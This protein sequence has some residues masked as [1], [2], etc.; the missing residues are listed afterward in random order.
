MQN[1]LT[2][3]PVVQAWL[4][5]STPDD[6]GLLARL[7]GSASRAVHGYLQRPS[8]LLH[9]CAETYDGP[10]GGRLLLRQW[11][12]LSVASLSVGASPV[13]AAAA[14]GQSGYR[15]EAWDGYPP[16]SPQALDLS[17]YAYSPGAGNVAVAYT[18]G[19]AVLDEPHTVPTAAPL[20]V[21]VT[22]PCGPWAADQGVTLAD[23]TPLTAVTGTPA[24]GQYSVQSGRYAFAA[25]DA[26]TAVLVS[27]G[28]VPA[29]VEQACVE[30][31]GERYRTKDRIGE[32]SKTLGGQETVSFSTD[33]MNKHVRELLQPF[34]RLPLC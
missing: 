27:Y 16:G 26:G 32:N 28:F 21:A 19:Y 9:P 18:A 11:P 5:I 7:I 34:R 2:S 24:A 31:V 4:G 13:P 22:A 15:L 20:S 8:L 29:D 17:G 6:N 12:V 14:Y 1:H 3:L 10:G 23:G 25:A 30:L 33:S